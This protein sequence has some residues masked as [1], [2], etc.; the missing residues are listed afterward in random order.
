MYV[1]GY[2]YL[3]AGMRTQLDSNGKE[4]HMVDQHVVYVWNLSDELGIR[5]M[6][7]KHVMLQSA[8]RFYVEC[9]LMFACLF[10]GCVM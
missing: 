8:D 1:H 4:K 9:E 6:Y 10:L 7:H 2:S 3:R 5:C